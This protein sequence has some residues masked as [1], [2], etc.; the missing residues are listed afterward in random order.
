MWGA[1]IGVFGGWKA[2]PHS[3]AALCLGET[4]LH[5][6]PPPR[7]LWARSEHPRILPNPEF[8]S[9]WIHASATLS[10]RFLG[11]DGYVKVSSTQ[12]EGT[13]SRPSTRLRL[14]GSATCWIHATAHLSA[15]LRRDRGGD[16]GRERA[17][18][19]FLAEPRNDRELGRG[20]EMRD[21]S[22]EV[23]DASRFRRTLQRRMFHLQRGASE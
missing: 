15:C 9:P 19:R 17:S 22:A 13:G 3:S 2:C 8:S 7:D 20:V 10:A 16:E 12:G 6:F 21:V 1:I 11:N 23:L 5:S 4:P 18:P 14:S